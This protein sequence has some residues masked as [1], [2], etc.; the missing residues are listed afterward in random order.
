MPKNIV[1]FSDGTG[2]S[3]K[4][5]FKTNVWRL[6]QALDLSAPGQVAYYDD[7][8]GTSS[9]KLY[10][11][12]SGAI[13][14]GL[15][16]NIKHIY[17]F[18]SRNYRPG[19]RIYGFG[20]SRGAFTMRILIGLVHN[21]GLARGAT[22]AELWRDVDSKWWAY[23]KGARTKVFGK[24]RTLLFGKFRA[25]QEQ[26][27]DPD[28][29]FTFVGLWDTVNAYGLPIDELTRAWDQYIWPLSMNDRFPCG[30]IEKA[31]H[32]LSI[33]DERN[34]FHPVLW[35]EEREPHNAA[36]ANLNDERISQVW[37]A[38]V[39][40]NVGGS[41][42]DDSLAHVPLYWIMDEARRRGLNFQ[43]GKLPRT[44]VSAVTKGPIYDSR[45]GLSGY[46]RYNPRKITKLIK[47]A[48]HGVSIARP[49]IHESVF[50]RMISGTDR[51]APII[52]PEQYAV[53]HANGS[54]VNAAVE[55]PSQ[56]QARAV[57]QER[58]WNWVW[59]RRVVYFASV[60]SSF[61]LA[62]FP[63]LF[64]DGAC[65][66][67]FFCFLNLPITIVGSFL[68]AFAAPWINTFK[69]N[70][71]RFLLIA[72]F[73]V[74]CLWTGGWLSR[75]IRDTMRLI[76]NPILAAPGAAVPPGRPPSGVIAGSVY[77]LRTRRA[78]EGFFRWL[79]RRFL[80]VLFALSI[81]YT[82]AALVSRVT[83]SIFSAAGAVCTKS[84]QP[85]PLD[86]PFKFELKDL[87][88][89]TGYLLQ[90]GARYRIWIDTSED[91]ADNEIKTD[92]EGFSRWWLYGAIPFRRWLAEPWFKPIA[93]I[94]THGNDEYPIE[95]LVPFAAGSPKRLLAT[96]IQARRSG[97]L[98]LYVNDAV[99]FYPSRWCGFEKGPLGIRCEFYSNNH[100]TAVVKIQRIE[101][102]PM[103]K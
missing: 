18:L 61:Y 67:N 63:L 79:T 44:E 51:Y 39:H 6:Y 50:E 78:Y 11:I 99:M 81:Y 7:G 8:V 3:S 48:Y 71:G 75:K 21:Q 88:A 26:A 5:L 66:S 22:E 85:R 102:P 9:F 92:V 15:K 35:T 52:L 27:A 40:S 38:G 65:A 56:S 64:E 36:S 16:R 73:I 24:F 60:L 25:S 46:Y 82:G 49:K 42:P 53:V 23:R 90:D 47:D 29:K 103:P 83:F 72:S 34:T 32:A 70:P 30:S 84:A 10:A 33:D 91:W 89:A 14:L 97:E 43:Y 101:A 17:A 87:C 57:E 4:A 100:G 93:R 98:F 41:Y 55:S 12:L 1:L 58:A 74:A 31:F 86:A 45:R 96:E 95:P 62:L 19:D 76:W 94:G 69:A 59:A 28:V 37:F 13:G 77:W 68:P 80:P 20:F 2:N 54:I